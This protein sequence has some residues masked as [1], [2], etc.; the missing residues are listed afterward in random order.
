MKWQVEGTTNP[1]S[2]W[3]SQTRWDVERVREL[4]RNRVRD[5]CCQGWIALQLPARCPG[6]RAVQPARATAQGCAAFVIFQTS[7]CK[8]Q[9]QRVSISRNCVGV[10]A[11]VTLSTVLSLLGKGPGKTGGTTEGTWG[12]AICCSRTERTVE[13]LWFQELVMESW[14]PQAE[15]IRIARE[16][17]NSHIHEMTD[18][19]PLAKAVLN[20]PRGRGVFW[21]C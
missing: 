12:G 1:D 16:L 3:E 18:C 7:S 19:S 11:S 15:V 8:L 10:R 14:D 4:C 13:S 20:T 5:L 17:G 6:F 9:Q 21:L 2:S